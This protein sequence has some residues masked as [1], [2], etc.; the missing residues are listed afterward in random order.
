[1]IFFQCYVILY[2]KTTFLLINL[3]NIHIFIINIYIISTSA[4]HHHV[5]YMKV[6]K[7]VDKKP[8]F[9]PTT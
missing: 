1:M 2:A 7:V 8:I 5:T 4:L 6:N 3:R 9:T